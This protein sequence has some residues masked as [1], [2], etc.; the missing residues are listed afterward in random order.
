VSEWQEL[1][2]PELARWTIE[3]APTDHFRFVDG[4]LSVREPEGWLK[5][6]RLY[7]DFDCETEFRFLTDDADSG[8]F[9]RVR[10]QHPF[11]RGWPNQ[12]YQ[13]QIRN[14]LGPSPYP[15][16]GALFRHGMASGPTDY[17]E[18]LARAT[19]LPTG[20]WQT[21]AVRVMGDA[22]TVALNGVEITRAAGLRNETGHIGI[23]G[24]TGVLEFRSIRIRPAG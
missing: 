7:A 5:S 15:P 12:S 23:Q 13:V 17:D 21:L 3:D 19:C 11:R 16:V 14:P 8:L 22:L 4:V 20:A 2:D 18:P 10:G 24:E 1:I 6:D 9:V